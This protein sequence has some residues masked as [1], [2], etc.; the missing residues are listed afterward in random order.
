M[1]ESGEAQWA[2]S[3]SSATRGPRPAF[4]HH[5]ADGVEVEVQRKLHIGED[6]RHVPALPDE[7]LP[8]E[9]FLRPD[10]A[11][12]VIAEIAIKEHQRPRLAVLSR[13]VNAGGGAR[14]TEQPA[15]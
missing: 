6:L 8:G 7:A 3:P 12:V 9:L 15:K 11:I 10:I 13:A 4:D 2:A 14:G 5:L 1:P